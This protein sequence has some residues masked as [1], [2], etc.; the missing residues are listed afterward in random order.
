MNILI[1]YTLHTPTDTMKRKPPSEWKTPKEKSTTEI[2]AINK[3]KYES[4][5]PVRIRRQLKEDL[6]TLIEKNEGYSDVIQR[7][8]DFWNEKHK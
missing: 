7:L 2:Q 5:P 4:M 8:V 3:K 1:Y 6:Y